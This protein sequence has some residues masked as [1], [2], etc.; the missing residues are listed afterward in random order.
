MPTITKAP[1]PQEF[2]T[3]WTRG[4]AAAV[5]SEAG[6]DGRL[7]LREAQRIAE[8][9]GH[10]AQF[11][12][13]AVNYLEKTGQQS[14]SVNK[15]IGKGH[16]YAVAVSAKV[17][18][19]NNRISLVEARNL[20]DDLRADFFALR[21]KAD[22]G[23]VDASPARISGNDLVTAFDKA[24]ETDDGYGLT[25]TS[26]GDYNVLPVL[27]DNPTN[28]PV[29]GE[30]VMVLFEDLLLDGIFADVD[31][32]RAELTSETFSASESKAWLTEQSTYDP[33]WMDDWYKKES[34]GFAKVK[35]V[36]DANLEDVRVVKVG[37]KEDDG[38]LAVD[39]GT[40]AYF[41]VGKTDA[42]EI[43]GVW[44]GSAET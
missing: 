12:D 44:F 15:L 24:V 27:A 13:N 20:P 28:Q 43:A 39:H 19:D 25:Y 26:E 16:D 21:G 38:S 11:G 37:P 8:Q 14:V 41:I 29:N 3:A 17:A 32:Y 34:E 30:T 23:A 36:V 5:R 31:D 1:T 9:D 35:S 10:L 18:G 40:Y 7:S 2:A 22:P 42:N 4:F 33:S 6:R